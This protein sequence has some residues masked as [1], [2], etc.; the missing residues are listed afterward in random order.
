MNHFLVFFLVVFGH[1]IGST[2]LSCL[3]EFL[4]SDSLLD[5]FKIFFLEV[6]ISWSEYFFLEVLILLLD[7]IRGTCSL[8]LGCFW[9]FFFFDL[10]CLWLSSFKGDCLAWF[11]LVVLIEDCFSLSLIVVLWLL[12][13]WSKK[14]D[15]STV[16]FLKHILDG[17]FSIGSRSWEVCLHFT[18]NLRFKT[19]EKRWEMWKNSWIYMT[20]SRK[21][22][23]INFWAQFSKFE[24]F[25]GKTSKCYMTWDRFVQNVTVSNASK[26]K[27]WGLKPNQNIQKL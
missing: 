22:R 24:K 1:I 26:H 4:A 7:L 20:L 12:E 11:R 8:G 5:L 21:V 2:F 9:L 3:D 14:L 15:L 18:R 10:V 19:K 16:L 13:D 25:P 23:N 6:L 27:I 17:S